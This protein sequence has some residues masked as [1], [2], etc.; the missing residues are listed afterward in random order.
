MPQATT[1]TDSS[2][3]TP[4]VNLENNQFP[5]IS[6]E[7][8][9]AT[10]TQGPAHTPTISP[11]PSSEFDL[12]STP[13]ASTSIARLLA[14]PLS[15]NT[16]AT[17]H[18]TDLGV[19]PP[20]IIPGM[21]FSSVSAL[22]PG[23]LLPEDPRVAQASPGSQIDQLTPGPGFLPLG[24][25]TAVPQVT[26]VSLPNLAPNDAAFDT[27]DNSRVPNFFNN[28]EAPHHPYQLDMSVPDIAMELS[29]RSLYTVPSSCDI[30]RPGQ[31]DIQP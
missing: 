27:H 13:A 17:P 4:P 16:V 18:N 8:A 23:N 5:A 31:R 22:A 1:I 15:S 19:V 2:H 26:S 28:I 30:D 12:H 11:A 6:L 24:S 20:S 21:P 7:S 10:A 29:R 9:T 14:T 25:V 3:L